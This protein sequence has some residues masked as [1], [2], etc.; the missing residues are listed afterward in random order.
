MKIARIAGTALQKGQAAAKLEDLLPK[1]S[2]TISILQAFGS[3][4]GQVPLGNKI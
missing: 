1:S 4:S 2:T 3:R